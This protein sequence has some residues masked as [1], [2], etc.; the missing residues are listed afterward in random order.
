[1][2][3]GHVFEVCERI[4][5]AQALLHQHFDAGSLTADE[6]LARL[7]RLLSEPGLLDAMYYIGYFPKQGAQPTSQ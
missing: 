3:Q 1:M 6:T 5:E 7:R 2:W 4:S